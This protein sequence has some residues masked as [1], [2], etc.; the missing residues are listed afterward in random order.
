MN[1]LWRGTC[2]PVVY[3]AVP[4]NT[5]TADDLRNVILASAVVQEWTEGFVFSVL[6][7]QNS[8]LSD[9]YEVA[10]P[11]TSSTT[12][13]V[14]AF[15]GLHSGVVQG[16]GEQGMVQVGRSCT[17]ARSWLKQGAE[18]WRIIPAL[19]LNRCQERRYRCAS[20][21]RHGAVAMQVS[22]CVSGQAEREKRPRP[23]LYCH[24]KTGKFSETEL[25]RWLREEPTVRTVACYKHCSVRVGGERPFYISHKSI[26]YAN[27]YTSI[28]FNVLYVSYTLKNRTF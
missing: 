8:F 23:T 16:E 25:N 18:N 17:W 19:W 1:A 5:D 24:L 14:K 27:T 20:V 3:R 7:F 10:A 21:L 22:A 12:C 11:N 9:Y 4:E 6:F 2:T 15:G 13:I 28:L 26:N